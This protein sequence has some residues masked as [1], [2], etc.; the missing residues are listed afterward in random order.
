MLFIIKWNSPINFSGSNQGL[1]WLA[2]WMLI[3]G[4]YITVD[5]QYLPLLMLP[6]QTTKND[7][8]SYSSLLNAVFQMAFESKTL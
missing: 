2:L 7:A 1:Y 4:L 8:T 3:P 6:T 5:L